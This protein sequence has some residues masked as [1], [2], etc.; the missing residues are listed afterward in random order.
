MSQDDYDTIA[1]L[2][3]KACKSQWYD[4]AGDLKSVRSYFIHEC[5]YDARLH[6]YIDSSLIEPISQVDYQIL[7]GILKKAQESSFYK[8]VM[9]LRIAIN[10][11]KSRLNQEWTREILERLLN[12]AKN[13]IG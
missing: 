2:V 11:L 8:T 13:E 5:S 3:H 9:H 4:L 7:L 6:S 1:L 10:S 12:E